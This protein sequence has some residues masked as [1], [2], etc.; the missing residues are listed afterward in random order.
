[1]SMKSVQIRGV[2]VYESQWRGPGYRSWTVTEWTLLIFLSLEFFLS[3]FQASSLESRHFMV[4]GLGVAC[5]DRRMAMPVFCV[6]D[7]T[8]CSEHL[9]SSEYVLHVN[10]FITRLRQINL[11]SKQ[12]S[13]LEATFPCLFQSLSSDPRSDFFQI[14]YLF[15][16]FIPLIPQ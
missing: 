3:M 8:A 12:E 1:M 15:I 4:L 9:H 16:F 6:T 7:T 11:V 2:S 5:K 10:H 14:W 13:L